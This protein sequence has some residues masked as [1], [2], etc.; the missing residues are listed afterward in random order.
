MEGGFGIMASRSSGFSECGGFNR[1]RAEDLHRGYIWCFL[2]LC[3]GQYGTSGRLG[4]SIM[5]CTG[6]LIPA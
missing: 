3:L 4:L 6:E 1:G 5:Q 2:R